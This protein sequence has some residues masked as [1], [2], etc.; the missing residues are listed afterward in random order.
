[1]SL[2]VPTIL[3]LTV[4]VALLPGALLVFSWAQNRSHRSLAW[5]GA[6]NLVGG[7]GAALLAARGKIPD[8]LSID[9][10][11]ALLFLGYGAMICAARQFAGRRIDFRLLF[12]GAALWLIF[13]Q[14]PALHASTVARICVV[15]AGVVVY[16]WGVAYILLRDRTERLAS[17]VPAAA[18][19]GLHGCI[20]LMRIPIA[21]L[22]A[23][24]SE[25]DLMSHP[26]IGFLA[27]ESMIQLIAMSFLQIGMEKE[28]AEAN[29]RLAAQT[30][31][32]TGAANRRS[33]L[34]RADGLLASCRERNVS[35]AVLLLDLDH[36][37]SVNDRFGHDIGDSVLK[38]TA[39]TLSQ[40]LR[41]GDLF[42]RVGGE[43]F[44]CC[45]TLRRLRPSLSRN[46][47]APRFPS[48]VSCPP[49]ARS[50]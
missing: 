9:L 42:G 10:A 31:E 3:F 20:C 33:I 18:W 43:E 39:Q 4:L 22:G 16:S 34:E 35:A 19:A 41:K 5:W 15:S 14:V 47:F 11:N 36:F 28:R 23:P 50:A 17:R 13:C 12:G 6:A 32:L 44:V 8:F 1:M 21:L 38:A 37:K 2:H 24:I 46:A 30:D 25:A 45:P 49:A 29:Q 26:L 27:V 48:S 7:T 40:V